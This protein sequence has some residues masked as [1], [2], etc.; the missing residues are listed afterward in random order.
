MN[1]HQ[2][3]IC[4]LVST[5]VLAHRRK[6]LGQNSNG[7]LIESC[8]HHKHRDSQPIWLF[9]KVLFAQLQ[10]ISNII[11][12]WEV[13]NM[14]WMGI[15]NIWGYLKTKTRKNQQ[16][17]QNKALKT[18]L[19]ISFREAVNVHCHCCTIHNSQYIEAIWVPTNRVLKKV[20]HISIM[21]YF[22]PKNEI[23]SFIRGQMKL[24]ALWLIKWSKYKK[25]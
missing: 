8:F 19:F 14:S 2:C 25:D 4:V 13:R 17:Q 3:N 24:R 11:L 5:A 1:L 22:Q 18:E 20:K 12:V 7:I 10:V 6:Q 21:C 9:P 15:N 16:E 23:K